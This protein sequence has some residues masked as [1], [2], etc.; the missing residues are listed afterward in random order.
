MTKS[1]GRREK[2]GLDMGLRAAPWWLLLLVCISQADPGRAGAKG[3]EGKNQAFHERLTKGGVSHSLPSHSSQEDTFR[4][5]PKRPKVLR[6]R[7][8]CRSLQVEV[9]RTP[10]WPS[11]VR[12]RARVDFCSP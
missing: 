1:W 8:F 4:R 11:L 7:R 9:F 6:T 3:R 12:E 2:S 10:R 5:T